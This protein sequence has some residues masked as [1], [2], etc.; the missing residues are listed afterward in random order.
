MSPIASLDRSLLTPIVRKVLQND[1]VEVA[2]WSSRRMN[3]PVSVTTGGAFRIVGT[4]TDRGSRQPWSVVLKIVI[5]AE[6]MNDPALD[7]YW[8]REILAYESGFLGTLTGSIVAPRCYEISTRPSG[9]VWIWLEEVVDDVGREWSIERLD[10]VARH[11]GNFS[12]TYL[13]PR[14]PDEPWLGRNFLRSW[15]SQ[16]VTRVGARLTALEQ[17]D[18]LQDS[19]RWEHQ[20]MKRAFP[21]PPIDRLVRLWENR[22]RLLDGVERLPQVLSHLDINSDNIFTR[23]RPGAKEQTVAIDWAFLSIAGIGEEAGHFA[24]WPVAHRSKEVPAEVTDRIL[25]DAYLA[26]LGEAGWRGDRRLVR[27]GY[28]THAALRWGFRPVTN[29]LIETQSWPKSSTPDRPYPDSLLSWAASTAAQSRFTLDRG[30]EA[31]NL[32]AAL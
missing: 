20:V 28:A 11:L 14:V 29:L 31:A 18:M 3:E 17:L 30:D 26:G 4:T 6:G 9:N 21:H 27:L 2:E 10:M 23:K 25:F 8:K 24:T 19:Q 7:Q 16:G 22:A 13:G 32:L 5:P 12:G 15:V 1:I